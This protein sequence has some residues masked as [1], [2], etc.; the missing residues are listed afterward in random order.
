MVNNT[1]DWINICDDR[2]SKFRNRKN[3]QDFESFG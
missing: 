1:K 2:F 3:L